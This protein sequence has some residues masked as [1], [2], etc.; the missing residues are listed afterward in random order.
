[1]SYL[2]LKSTKTV[3]INIHMVC[4][5]ENAINY[6]QPS[7]DNRYCFAFFYYIGYFLLNGNFCVKWAF[8]SLRSITPRI[9]K[10]IQYLRKHG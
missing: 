1:M 3:K 2:F 9:D 8:K 4:G 7:V 10:K 6:V 5:T